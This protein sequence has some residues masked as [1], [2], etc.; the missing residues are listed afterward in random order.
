MTVRQLLQITAG[1]AG[2]GVALV[3]TYHRLRH[4]RWA[5]VR[6]H[7]WSSVR[8][9]YQSLAIYQFAWRVDKA[10]SL[11]PPPIDALG[12]LKGG[13]EV[14]A[15]ILASG[16]ETFQSKPSN[17]QQ[18]ES[19]MDCVYGLVKSVRLTGATPVL[20][21]MGAGKALFTRAM[22]EALGRQVAAIAMDLRGPKV[23]DHFYD[24]P[25]SVDDEIT[26]EEQHRNAVRSNHQNDKPF[27]RIVADVNRLSSR[28]V[29]LGSALQEGKHGGVIAITKH[30][31]GGATDGS[32][33]AICASPLDDFVGACCLA[34]CCHQKTLKAQYCN[35]A[36]LE[37]QGFCETHIGLR[38]SEEDSDF[39]T[40]GMLISMSKSD[41]LKHWEYKKSTLLKLLGI[42]R[43]RELGFKVRR[44]LEE[45][46]IRYL[47]ANGFDAHL[48]RYCENTVT[49]DNLAIIA[50]R[51]S[52]D[53]AV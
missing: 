45:G 36:F 18:I 19:L 21:D 40:F 49:F 29:R 17:R 26:L 44:I 47:E 8:Y 28:T 11:L 12:V 27:T 53:D 25:T 32:I 46:R 51:V 14:L 33:V 42:P 3:L 30:L 13:D 41:D 4:D 6:R 10:Y 9:V 52:V 22:Y 38:G 15:Q 39:R 7:P 34:P 43:A 48:V 2:S 1:C 5:T 35:V 50:R 23:R 37:S 16:P 24:P 31:C 20:L